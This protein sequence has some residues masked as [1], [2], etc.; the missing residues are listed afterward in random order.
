[1]ALACSWAYADTTWSRLAAL[2]TCVLECA[3]Q[4]DAVAT[5]ILDAAAQELA[6]SVQAV[7]ARLTFQEGTAVV[8]AGGLLGDG[9]MFA[10]KVEAAVQQAV[11]GARLK[12]ADRDA[13]VG[14]ALLACRQLLRG[15]E[16][17]CV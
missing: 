9:S 16:R 6:S 11:P 1:M 17:T 5:G 2:A 3:E 10:G 14:A 15:G 8:L 12:R 13:A 7:W 4:G